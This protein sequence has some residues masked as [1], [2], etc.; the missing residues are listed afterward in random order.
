ME[1]M[2]YC[3]DMREERI[4]LSHVNHLDLNSCILIQSSHKVAFY[5]LC[6]LILMSS[7]EITE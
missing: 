3:R 6:H 5:L 4:P 7:L 1:L 2:L